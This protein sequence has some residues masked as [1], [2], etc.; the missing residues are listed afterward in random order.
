MKFRAA[1]LEAIESRKGQD[2]LALALAFNAKL[3]SRVGGEKVTPST[4]Q[5]LS[6]ER[7]LLIVDRL[8]EHLSTLSARPAHA[9]NRPFQHSL[10]L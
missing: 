8:C 1:Q 4:I 2:S 10:P 7:K 9:G 3:V 6:E 5:T